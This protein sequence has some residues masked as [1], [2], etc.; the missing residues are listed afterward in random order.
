[1]DEIAAAE[2]KVLSLQ[3]ALQQAEW[4]LGQKHQSAPQAGLVFDTLYRQGD[5]VGAGLP[6]VMLLPPAT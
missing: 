4:E 3:A 6:V 5:W 2:A 1:V